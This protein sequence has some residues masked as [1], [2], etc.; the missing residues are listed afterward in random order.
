MS[1]LEDYQVEVKEVQNVEKWST[2]KGHAETTSS[3]EGA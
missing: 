2:E 1:S 3:I